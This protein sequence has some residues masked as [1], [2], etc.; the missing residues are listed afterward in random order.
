M[1]F[2]RFSG[3]CNGDCF[4]V[5][6][7]DAKSLTED[8]TSE[9]F[10]GD[11]Y[12]YAP[13]R[14]LSDTEYTMAKELLSSIPKELLTS[15]QQVYGCPDCADQG[16]YFLSFFYKGIEK[17]FRLDTRQTDDQSADLLTF[18]QKLSEVIQSIQ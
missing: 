6:K 14:A 12:V 13:G 17:S 8:E 7:V 5:F 4:A 15:D 11:D 3:F 9:Y 2:G 10:T 18:K 1:I 16:G